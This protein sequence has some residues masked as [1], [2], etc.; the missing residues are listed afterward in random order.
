MK[1]VPFDIVGGRVKCL[2]RLKC[3]QVPVEGLAQDQQPFGGERV[4]FAL[5][6]PCKV[7][8]GGEKASHRNCDSQENHDGRGETPTQHGPPTYAV[9][10]SKAKFVQYF[11]ACHDDYFFQPCTNDR[12][13]P[14]GAAPGGTWRAMRGPPGSRWRASGAQNVSGLPPGRPC[15]ARR[16]G[17][18]EGGVAPPGGRV[19]FPAARVARCLKCRALP[20]NALLPGA[21]KMPR[22]NGSISSTS[23]IIIK[24]RWYR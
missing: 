4:E 12:F 3:P 24:D 21:S 7:R 8:S 19:L 5:G 16:I 20:R 23:S 9:R 15:F 11:S 10:A 6:F 17:L 18:R 1:P 2:D 22:W 14:A 13:G